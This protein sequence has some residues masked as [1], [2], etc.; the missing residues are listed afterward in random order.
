MRTCYRYVTFGV[1][2]TVL[3][4]KASL[5]GSQGMPMQ[6][7]EA[8][9]GLRQWIGRDNCAL[10]KWVAFHGG[11]AAAVE[12]F[13][14]MK[15]SKAL[16]LIISLLTP[17]VQ[18]PHV[19]FD[20]ATAVCSAFGLAAQCSEQMRL[21]VLTARLR[22]L[23]AI[24][25]SFDFQMKGEDYIDRSPWPV[26]WMDNM[27]NIIRS[28]MLLKQHELQVDPSR[29]VPARQALSSIRESRGGGRKRIA[30]VSV[31]DYDPGFTP[32]ARLS[33][34]NKQTY[35]QQHG[36]EAIIYDK[37]PLFEDPLVGYLTEPV[38]WRPAAWSKVDALL[39]TLAEGR[40]DWVMWMDCDSFFM[41]PE[42]QLEDLIAAAEVSQCGAAETAGDDQD[43][44]ALGD[45]LQRWM[46]GPP[47]M[48]DALSWYEKLMDSHMA[49]G[50]Y[51]CGGPQELPGEPPRN[52]TLGLGEWLFRQRRVHVIGSEDGLMLNTGNV[53][54][55]SSLWSWR[56]L[57]QA[58][59]MTFGKSPVTQHPWW[60][61][62]AMVYLLQLPVTLAHAAG[63]AISQVPTDMGLTAL[64]RGYV[65]A[66][67][68]FSQKHL[69]GYPP[70]VA[71]ALMTHDT[72]QF[73]DFIVS[74]SGC[75][76]YSSQEVC[77]H[78]FLGYFFRVHH[79]HNFQTD[80]S[81]QPW[82]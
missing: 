22:Q 16:G 26:K 44:Q 13:N 35:A 75:K 56:F 2:A 73:G 31:C 64:H 69:N 27:H 74:F 77:N 10:E 71:S 46:E 76:I 70:I 54:Y 48:T 47:T 20:C 78:L 65:R 53:L 60:E 52:G 39:R 23:S 79:F 33:Q 29:G 1:F 3:A 68:M 51:S 6:E 25:G 63:A 7:S 40:H 34:I 43:R 24:F 14:R 45:L 32:L 4:L 8:S 67:F 11:L 18:D 57:Q 19:A 41:D 59:W 50:D 62:T 9:P 5:G 82:F 66:C 55:R 81:L 49:D 12:E 36:Y 42:V 61:Q 38:S 58:R 28:M 15:F 30:I 21:N 72:F 37:A 17:V 80:P